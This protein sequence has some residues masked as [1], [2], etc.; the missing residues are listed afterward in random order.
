[1]KLGLIGKGLIPELLDKTVRETCLNE[2]PSPLICPCGRADT[3][4]A[5][6]H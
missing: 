2:G 1:M 5:L 4:K 3:C 6:G